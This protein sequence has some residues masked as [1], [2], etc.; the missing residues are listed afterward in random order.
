MD[1]SPH[2][3]RVVGCLIEKQLTT[4]Q[5]YP[6]TLSALVSACNQSSNRYPVVNYTEEMVESAVRELKVRGLTR[7]VHPSHGRSALRYEHRLDEVLG[8]DEPQL[9]LLA[10]L[11]LRGPQTLGELRARTERMANFGGLDAVEHE[12]GRLGEGQEPLTVELLR[13]PGQKERRYAHLL[14]GEPE[15][16]GPGEVDRT[17]D[18]YLGDNLHRAGSS[19]GDS[20]QQSRRVPD[21]L[22]DE[23]TSLRSEMAE[24]RDEMVMVQRQLA[25]LRELLDI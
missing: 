16:V 12:L 20:D 17:A 18:P 11:G 13:R 3:V 8:L 15:A 22:V 21:L 1:L 14:S 10:V 7:F 19:T 25:E 6:L 23:I 2:E 4:P 5:Q 9:A 24:L